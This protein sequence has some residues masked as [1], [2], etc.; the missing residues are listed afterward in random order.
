M[1]AYL[2]KQLPLPAARRKF[3]PW[4]LKLYAQRL[5]LEVMRLAMANARLRERL[6]RYAKG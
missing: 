2:R 6:M 5:E 3:K 1:T 4:Q